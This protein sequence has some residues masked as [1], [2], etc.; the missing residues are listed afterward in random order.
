MKKIAIAISAA[1]LV[2]LLSSCSECDT[3]E[4][5]NAKAAFEKQQAEA[6]ERREAA[7]NAFRIERLKAEA[8]IEKAKPESVRL[9][10]AKNQE[11]TAGE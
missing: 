7:E 10:E 3:A 1:V 2:F 9:Q 4:C 5:W 11:T 6:K 8:E